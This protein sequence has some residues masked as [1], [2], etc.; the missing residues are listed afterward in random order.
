MIISFSLH[1]TRY[2][3]LHSINREAEAH[4]SCTISKQQ[5]WDLNLHLTLEM[6]PP[7]ST[8]GII[9]DP[10]MWNAQT[11]RASSRLTQT[12]A[13]REKPSLCVKCVPIRVIFSVLTDGSQNC[14]QFWL[15]NC[16]LTK[17]GEGG[18][19]LQQGHKDTA[20]R[21]EPRPFL[22]LG[23][24]RKSWAPPR[25]S[26]HVQKGDVENGLKVMLS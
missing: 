5:S 3:H 2:Y 15:L 25:W 20:G 24:A 14:H 4:R 9:N 23:Q 1:N 7:L 13:E 10:L 26:S 11:R 16:F 21:K 8:S 18:T 6:A 17:E 12:G 19:T 22:P